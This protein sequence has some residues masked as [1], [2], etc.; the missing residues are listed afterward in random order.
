MDRGGKN[1]NT[2]LGPLCFCALCLYGEGKSKASGTTE[3]RRPQAR[4]IAVTR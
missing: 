3:E 2:D 1:V 4:L